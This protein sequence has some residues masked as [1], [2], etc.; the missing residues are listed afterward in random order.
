MKIPK[1]L[2]QISDLRPAKY[3]REQIKETCHDWKYVHFIESEILS[4]INFNPL[5]EFENSLEKFKSGSTVYK[6]NF[7]KYYFL[8]INGGVYL[9]SQCMIEKNLLVRER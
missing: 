4:Y 9:N 3:L 5:P 6:T 7:F 1:I 2:F 8:Y